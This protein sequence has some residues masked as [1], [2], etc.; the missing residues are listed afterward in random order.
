MRSNYLKTLKTAVLAISVLLLGASVSFAQQTINLAAGPSSITLPDG[1]IVPMWG[2]TCGPLV[3]GSTATCGSLSRTSTG[4]SPVV[5]TVPTGQGL[6]INLTN[7]LSFTPLGSTTPNQI[8]TSLVIVGQLGGGLGVVAQRTTA[9]SPQHLQQGPTWPI[10]GD[11]SG[12]VFNPPPQQDRVQSFASEVVVGTPQNL[13]WSNLRP[14]T[15]L[16]ESGTHPS[17]QG[18]MVCTESWWSRPSPMERPRDRHI[19]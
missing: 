7:N 17:I 1:S 14:G 9:P 6:Q 18:P 5:I 11:N 3:T 2:Y 10:A 12:A 19:R 16:I 13:T 4:W 15:Y 8:P